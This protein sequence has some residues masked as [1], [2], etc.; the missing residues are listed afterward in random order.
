MLKAPFKYLIKINE[1]HSTG[2][3]R[4][5]SG[6]FTN[7]GEAREEWDDLTKYSRCDDTILVEATLQNS[8]YEILDAFTMPITK[9]IDKVKEVK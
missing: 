7:Y 2:A 3:L 8:R 9:I 4:Q 1:K 6:L 5:Y